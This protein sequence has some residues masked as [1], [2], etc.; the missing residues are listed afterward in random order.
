MVHFIVTL[1]TSAFVLLAHTAILI[2]INMDNTFSPQ[3][4]YIFHMLVIATTLSKSSC[5]LI[6]SDMVVFCVRSMEGNVGTLGLQSYN[7]RI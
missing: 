4:T 3:S 2:W 5:K 7:L 6:L 1:W